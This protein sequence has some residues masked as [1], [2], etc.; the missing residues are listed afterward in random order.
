MYLCVYVC[1]YMHVHTLNK[2]IKKSSKKVLLLE[3]WRNFV[4]SF[5]KQLEWEHTKT[6]PSVLSSSSN[7]NL[8]KHTLFLTPPQQVPE[9]TLVA[10]DHRHD[11]ALLEDFCDGIKGRTH[12]LFSTRSLQLIMYFDELEICNPIGSVTKK[13]ARLVHWLCST[14]AIAGSV[15]NFPFLSLFHY[16]HAHIKSCAESACY[17]PSSNL[18]FSGY[19][20]IMV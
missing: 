3:R 15:V 9:Y 20:V 6:Y 18:L 4:A 17:I 5:P 7:Q 12:T 11:D 1:V 16:F 14:I 8:S 2:R 19:E 13:Q 10:T